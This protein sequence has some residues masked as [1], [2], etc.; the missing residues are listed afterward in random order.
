M[1]TGHTEV[2]V[3][4]GSA[5]VKVRLKPYRSRQVRVPGGATRSIRI[6]LKERVGIANAQVMGS[7]IERVVTANGARFYVDHAHPEYS[8]PECTNAFD[9][10][11]YDAA[12]D[13]R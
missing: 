9:A 4:S 5:N 7:P 8:S 3:R 10:M 12:G 6:E 1:A 11:L 13:N 2:T